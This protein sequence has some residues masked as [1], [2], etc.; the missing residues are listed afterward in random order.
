MRS[1]TAMLDDPRPEHR[2]AALWA[3]SRTA[4]R[5]TEASGGPEVVRRVMNMASEQGEVEAL[6]PRAQ[7]A[8]ER[9]AAV[10]RLGWS[11]R[12][13]SGAVATVS[14]VAA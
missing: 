12:A 4:E 9:L 2:L 10:V 1:L 14:E 11:E 8:A 3:V 5:C 7:Q 13:A 6:R